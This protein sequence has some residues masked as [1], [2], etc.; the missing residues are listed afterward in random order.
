MTLRGCVL[1]RVG[2]LLVVLAVFGLGVVTPSAAETVCPTTTRVFTVDAK[3]G[4]LGEI[5]RCFTGDSWQ[6]RPMGEVDSADWRTYSKVFGAYDGDAAILY[7]VTASGELWWRR[8]T[9]SG[10][11]L[12][13]PVRVGDTVDW[14]HDVVFVASPG[15]LELG[16]FG[17]PVRTFRHEGWSS[18]GTVV[19][20]DSVLL[21]IFHG[22]AIT[23]VTGAG[24]AL[25]N[26]DGVEYRVW[27]QSGGTHD[28][29]WYASGKLPAGVSGVTGDGT[30]LY[31]VESGGVVL[32]EQ[33]LSLCRIANRHDWRVSARAPG[34]F[35]RVVV[36]VRANADV[37][38][39]MAPTP[40]MDPRLLRA[41]TGGNGPDL[42]PWEWQ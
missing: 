36:P 26:W 34:R 7:A 3:T 39:S 18:G 8:Q 33:T 23:A 2:C 11:T 42:D 37:R 28:D 22:P 30:E 25:G 29:V 13:A 1:N 15:Y 24:N 12:G 32:L 5:R 41:C 38:P 6:L 10:A 17:G 35:S 14:R 16:D 21:T 9:A 4:H 20:E 27:R 19:S 40:Q 31:G